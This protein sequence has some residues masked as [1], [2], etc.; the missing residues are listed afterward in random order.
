[1]EMMSCIISWKSSLRLRI[2]SLFG[3]FTKEES[4]QPHILIDMSTTI[5]IFLLEFH[6]E[7]S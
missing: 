4:E 2:K 7:V 5:L 3:F 6:N 1:M